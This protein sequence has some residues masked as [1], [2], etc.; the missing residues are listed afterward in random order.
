MIKPVTTMAGVYKD[1]EK[2]LNL[3]HRNHIT[4]P[5][6]VDEGRPHIFGE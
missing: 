2:R 3:E 6:S 1:F 5:D 4:S